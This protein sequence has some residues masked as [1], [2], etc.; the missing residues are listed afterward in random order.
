MLNLLILYM[1]SRSKTLECCFQS[2]KEVKWIKKS[3]CKRS[4]WR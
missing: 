4:L 1:Q 3:C 2:S